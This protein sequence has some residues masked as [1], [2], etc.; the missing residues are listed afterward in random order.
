VSHYKS[1]LPTTEAYNM[2]ALLENIAYYLLKAVFTSFY[3]F[4]CKKK[5][6]NVMG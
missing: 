4:N 3:P 5:D 2:L 6:Y 1:N